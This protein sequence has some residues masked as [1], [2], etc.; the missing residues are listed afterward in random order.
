MNLFFDTSALVK[1]F[2][3]EQGSASVTTLI[4][5]PGNA[6]WILDLARL[7]YASALFRRHR[8]REIDDVLL[9]EAIA[10]FDEQCGSYHV[11]PLSPAFVQEAER[12]LREYGKKHG[13]RTLDALHIAAYSLL[14]EPDWRL[15]TADAGQMQVARLLSWHVLNPLAA[16]PLA[17]NSA[18][19]T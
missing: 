11:E 18:D 10:G 4:Q 7:E 9:E 19:H 15:V 5:D 8:N 3:E 1:I 13:L 2:H 17:G 6:V 16:S 12:L 14:A